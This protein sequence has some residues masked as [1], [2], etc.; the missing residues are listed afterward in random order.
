MS[1]SGYTKLFNSILASTIWRAPDHT[2][3]VWI[4][5]LAMSDKD[6]VCEGSIPGLADLA[7][8]T[9]DQCEE[10]L[11]ELHSPD[12][13]SRT[14][15]HEGRRIE[16]IDGVGWQLLNHAKYRVK[17]SED[18]RREYNRMKQAEW[19]KKQKEGLSKP[20]NKSQTMSM[21]VN[22]SQSLSAMSA[23]TDTDTEANTDKK[24][25]K[26]KSAPKKINPSPDE[27]FPKLQEE[28]I[29][30]HIDF[31]REFRKAEIWIADHPGRQMS[32][33]FFVNWINKI[34]APQKEEPLPMGTF[35][36]FDLPDMGKPILTEEPDPEGV[37]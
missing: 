15:E 9:V 37:C 33:A 4:T 5:L 21:T 20:V 22:D 8:V 30:S 7:H 29:Y 27:W 31:T 36:Y 16:T 32:K 23:H 24:E 17:M 14:S 12:P 35:E 1:M 6:G 3:L 13:Y 10:A 26:K 11:V 18:E 28:S 2:R 25:K 34:E 19:R